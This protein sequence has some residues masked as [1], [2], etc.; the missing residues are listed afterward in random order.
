MS[1]DFSKSGVTVDLIATGMSDYISNSSRIY[2]E[3]SYFLSFAKNSCMS[4]LVPC[5]FLT[6]CWKH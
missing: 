6:A 4:W 5:K 3:R 1:A 2:C